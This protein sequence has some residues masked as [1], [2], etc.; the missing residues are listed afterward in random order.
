ME[1]ISRTVELLVGIVLFSMLINVL[2]TRLACE[3]KVLSDDL[4]SYTGQRA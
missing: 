1:E 2:E 3:A 4:K